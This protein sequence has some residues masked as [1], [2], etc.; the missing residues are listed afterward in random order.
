MAMVPSKTFYCPAESQYFFI[1]IK[2]FPDQNFN[3]VD[4]KTDD[5]KTPVNGK[6]NKSALLSLSDL[7]FTLP[8]ELS[9]S[10]KCGDWHNP[11]NS[12]ARLILQLH[13]IL[14]YTSNK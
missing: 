11:Q 10:P 13:Q 8:F 2:C 4:K 1:M 12:R 3:R 14:Q 5:T 6:Q 7:F 9:V